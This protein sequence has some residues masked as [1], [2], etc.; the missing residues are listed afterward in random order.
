MI[1]LDKGNKGNTHMNVV[2]FVNFTFLYSYRYEPLNSQWH[3]QYQCEL[4]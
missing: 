1:D 4:V 3:I 2:N